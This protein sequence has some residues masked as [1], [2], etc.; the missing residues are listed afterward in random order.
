[1]TVPTPV[2]IYARFST[3][4]QDSRSA[5]D[6]ARRCRVFAKERGWDVVEV[7]KDEG[8]SGRSLDRPAFQA[9]LAEAGKGKRCRFKAVLVDAPSRLGRDLGI[10][11][12]TIFEDLAAA[13]I[14][15][16]DV[17]SGSSSVQPNARLLFGVQ[18]LIADAYLETLRK[19]THRGLE[20][21]ALEGFSAGGRC[22][23]YE[24]FDEPNP[25]DPEHPRRLLRVDEE[26]ARLVRRIFVGYANGK[27]LAAL[28]DELNGEA[29]A[30][31]DDGQAKKNARGWSR[32]LL[33]SMLRNERYLGKI[34]WNKREWFK[35][36]VT[37]KRRYRERP[38]REWVRT[39]DP[40]LAIIDQ[41]TWDAV[42]ARHRVQTKQPTRKTRDGRYHE[43][44][45]S[46]LL[47][48]GTCGGP[49]SIVGRKY[50]NG[51]SWASYG[52]SVNQSRGESVCPNKKTVS[53]RIA[54]QTVLALLSSAVRS[55]DFKNWVRDSMALAA[56]QH[57]KNKAANDAVARLEKDVQTQTAAVERI[58]NRLIEV[59]ASDFL[60]ERL[61]AE[62]AKLR[63]LRHAL[64]K[65]SIPKQA[66]PARKV[67]LDQVLAVLQQVERV[68]AKS[69]AR[70]REVLAS[71]MDPVVLTPTP[72]GYE[73][74]LTLRNETAA[75]AGG[76]TLLSESC[77]GA[78]R[79]LE[80]TVSMPV[81][82]QISARRGLRALRR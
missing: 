5:D 82:T 46:G 9:M 38:E 59:G 42:Q 22:F 74:S 51:L 50:E 13:G 7:F 71:V 32:S 66:A 41:A 29:V 34:V 69:P 6:Q 64:A 27:S 56:R 52:C 63:D 45:L 78:D 31:P 4:K 68:A 15:L 58:G 33:H 60:K 43:H 79:A 81:L 70:A 57:S 23:G 17:S 65:A 48:C 11:W 30:A 24:T 61:R 21:R 54:D 19:Q 55:K 25:T 39:E 10:T 1:M 18:G 72:E 75:L 77:G 62:E 47:R 2:A 14:A 49:M 53:E 26:E 76:R 12:R 44:L 67:S 80:R 37:R 73:A 20:S 16:W 8:V 35:D 28:V 36:P 3:D 40:K